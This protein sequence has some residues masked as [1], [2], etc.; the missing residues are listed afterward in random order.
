MRSTE[1]CLNGREKV[2][3]IGQRGGG[4]RMGVDLVLLTDRT[5]INEVLDKGCKSWP[6]V[7]SFKDRLGAEDPHMSREGGGVYGMEES[8]SGGWGHKHPSLEVQMTIVVVPVRE[9]GAREE[10][11]A[12]L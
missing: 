12:V 3:D 2:E 11:S 8:R 7:V 6:P 4:G 5:F 9:S 1:S 10:G